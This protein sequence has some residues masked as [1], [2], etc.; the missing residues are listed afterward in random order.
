M[1]AAQMFAL[2]MSTEKT[3]KAKEPRMYF[4]STR[5]AII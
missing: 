5:M 1:F 2:K 4:I 3:L